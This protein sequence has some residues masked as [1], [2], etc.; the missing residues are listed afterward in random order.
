MADTD[1]LTDW[2]GREEFVEEVISATPGKML[3]AMLNIPSQSTQEE[4]SVRP[5]GHW[6]FLFPTPLQSEL[7]E[8]GHE[9]RGVF[10]PPVTLPRRMFAGARISFL[11]PFRVGQKARRRGVITDIKEKRG[12]SGDL[13]FVSVHQE[14]EVEGELVL[15]EEQD[16]VYREAP[17]PDT[18]LAAASRPSR[19]PEYSRTYYPDEAMLFRY[20]ALIFNAHRI[21]YDRPYTEGQ[22]GY[23]GLVVHGQLV[24]TC[25]ADLAVRE[26][27][28][29]IATFSFRAVAPLFS[30]RPFNVHGARNGEGVDLWATDAEGNL[31]MSAEANFVRH[32]TAD[33]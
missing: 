29:N 27:G 30:G 2:I 17:R 25:L 24:A 4:D 3:A 8:D 12:R 32:R 19:V 22:E 15:T 14:I 10:M 9:R 26:W 33:A 23:P 20:S 16:I 7:A 28:A 5:L 13:V 31:A 18:R 1:I 21:H 6:T 11:R